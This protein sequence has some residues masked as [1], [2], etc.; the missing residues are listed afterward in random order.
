MAVNDDVSGLLDLVACPSCGGSLF[1]ESTC[2]R[3]KACGRVFDLRG[4]VP[5]LT[6]QAGSEHEKRLPARLR[7]ALL[8]NP[9]LYDLHQKYGGAGPIAAHVQ[10]HLTDVGPGTLL[11]IGAGT[12]MV[13]TLIQP[14]TRYIWF[15]ND[16]QKLR[17]FLGK[18]LGSFAVLGDAAS[19]P[20]RDLAA[21]W[22]V[23][24]EVS[25]HLP[26]DALRSCLEQTA[27]VTRSRFLFV[28][29]LRGERVRSK[30]LWHLDLG[31]FPRT[32]NEL[33]SHLRMPFDV[34]RIER[35]QVHHD[36]LVCV[37]LPRRDRVVTP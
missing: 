19:L 4:R 37:C 34:A 33:V 30:L 29:A 25:H 7:Y 20:F 12:G 16:R 13:A 35:F 1:A 22:T 11:D 6:E 17:G 18:E 3:C 36:H 27:R 31:R 14:E 28:D 10:K 24:V 15:D 26:D 2:L 5:V 32:E 21:D 8:G 9:R 23:M